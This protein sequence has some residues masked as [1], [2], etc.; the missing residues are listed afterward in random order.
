VRLATPFESR[1]DDHD[2]DYEDAEVPH[3]WYLEVTETAGGATAYTQVPFDG[4]NKRNRDDG[5]PKT[6]VVALR[7]D[8]SSGDYRWQSA[9]E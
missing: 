7:R 5:A 1:V 9:K 4:G 2:T 6:D 8:S 3:E